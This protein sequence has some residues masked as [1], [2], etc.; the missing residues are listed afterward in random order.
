[1][2]AW[3][4]NVGQYANFGWCSFF[5]PAFVGFEEAS[6]YWLVFSFSLLFVGTHARVGFAEADR[7]GSDRRIGLT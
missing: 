5:S 2:I 4:V 7:N 3:S 1:M 6:Y